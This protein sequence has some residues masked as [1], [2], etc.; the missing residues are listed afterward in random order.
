MTQFDFNVK[1]YPAKPGCY[2]MK[3]AIGQVIYVGKAKNLRSR[4]CSYFHVHRTT[5]QVKQLVAS[6]AD[7]EIILVNN[8]IESLILENHLIN[9][10][11][12]HYNRTLKEANSGYFYIVM[13]GEDIP[14]F[15]PYRKNR[16]NR[17]LEGIVGKAVE[18][19][20]GPYVNRQ[21]RD[22]LLKFVCE[23]F[24]IRTCKSMPQKVCLLYYLGKCSGPC[25]RRIS[26]EEYIAAIEH[27]SAFLSRRHVD[28][29]R[30]MKT[31]MLGYA[32]RLEFEKARRIRDRV[33]AL[34]STLGKQIIE[35]E[36]SHDQDVVYFGERKVLVMEI[37]RGIVQGLCLFDLDLTQ[38][39]TGVCDDFLLSHY[40]GSCPAELIVNQ[41]RN[42][43]KVEK[44]LTA[45]NEHT[46]RITL[47][48]R[49]V[50]YELLKLCEQNYYYRI[51][52]KK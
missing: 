28:L 10:Y 2:L 8:E 19:R 6:I 48:Q 40:A 23:T 30:E 43:E 44:A 42:L 47:P 29:I 39:H 24:Q 4:L 15:V 49:G 38:E 46:V 21:Y 26:H 5:S 13:T 9:Q 34:E 14:R 52:D 31:S 27:A 50:E 41:L 25:E 22:M 11:Q 20:F 33:K 17:E 12:P 18:R 36:V 51:S 1:R 32:K 7:I 45:P 16:I 3:N 37:K 35:R